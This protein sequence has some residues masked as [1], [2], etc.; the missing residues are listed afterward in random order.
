MEEK[1]A[2]LGNPTQPT[3]IPT[4]LKTLHSCILSSIFISTSIYYKCIVYYYY[5]FFLILCLY[6]G[7]LWLW[8]AS[9]R[10]FTELGDTSHSNNSSLSYPA[11]ILPSNVK[12]ELINQRLAIKVTMHGIVSFSSSFF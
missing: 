11:P 3:A 4:V 6:M 10:I 7:V 9:V 8:R 1:K 5:Y 12:S 2:I